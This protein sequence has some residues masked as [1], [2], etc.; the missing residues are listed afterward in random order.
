MLRCITH[1]FRAIFLSTAR[2]TKLGIGPGCGESIFINRVT[3]GASPGTNN[4][5]PKSAGK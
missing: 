4:S 3:P 2:I 1:P 5:G